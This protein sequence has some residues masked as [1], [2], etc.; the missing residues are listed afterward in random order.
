MDL[1]DTAWITAVAHVA[2][3]QRPGGWKLA[4]AHAA[5]CSDVGAASSEL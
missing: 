5:T 2:H 1:Q 4:S 3:S